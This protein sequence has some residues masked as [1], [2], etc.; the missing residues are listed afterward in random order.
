M[1]RFVWSSSLETVFTPIAPKQGD[2]RAIVYKKILIC[3]GLAVLSLQNV[4]SGLFQ[5]KTLADISDTE[6]VRRILQSFSLE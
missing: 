3:F 6:A 4:A 1:E 2:W 5:G